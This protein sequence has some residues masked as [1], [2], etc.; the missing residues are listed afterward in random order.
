[1]SGWAVTLLS[2]SKYNCHRG[3]GVPNQ[4]LAV[5]ILVNVMALFGVFFRDKHQNLIGQECAGEK[6]I[7]LESNH[8]SSE[9][10]E[11]NR[12]WYKAD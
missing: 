4:S 9:S 6:F 11:G 8:N 12:T 1:M 3:S 7:H 5:L 10:L 2:V